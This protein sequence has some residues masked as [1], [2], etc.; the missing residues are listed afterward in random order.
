MVALFEQ[1]RGTVDAF[2]ARA[3]A[4]HVGR[5]ER[6]DGVEVASGVGFA[7]SGRRCWRLRGRGGN[8][9]EREYRSDDGGLQK[10]A[11]PKPLVYS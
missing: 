1:M 6:F 10:A 4:L 11:R 7:E 5:G 8:D 2:S 9:G 3:A